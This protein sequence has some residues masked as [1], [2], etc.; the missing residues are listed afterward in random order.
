MTI[1]NV[2]IDSLRGILVP[3]ILKWLQVFLIAYLK[4]ELEELERSSL[5]P[6]QVNSSTW[7]NCYENG[8]STRAELTDIS[9]GGGPHSVVMFMK[10]DGKEY[11]NQN[12]SR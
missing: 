2:D 12:P 4:Q 5:H 11:Y 10:V 1:E 8:W 7:L 9:E 6:L 3:S